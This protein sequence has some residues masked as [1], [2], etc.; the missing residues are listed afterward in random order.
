MAGVARSDGSKCVAGARSSGQNSGSRLLKRRPTIEEM[1]L[2]GNK[3][4]LQFAASVQ[5]TTVVRLE[6]RA[7]TCSNPGWRWTRPILHRVSESNI[8]GGCGH[9]KICFSKSSALG[10]EQR[11]NF[12][13]KED[14]AIPEEDEQFE[15]DTAPHLSEFELQRAFQRPVL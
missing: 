13:L 11:E 5:R 7:R 2:P 3:G 4:S 8:D 6:E 15:P 14:E 12:D 9:F 1:L 10:G